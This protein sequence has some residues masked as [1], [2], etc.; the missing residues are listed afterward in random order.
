MKKLFFWI[1][2]FFIFQVK[3]FAQEIS[4]SNKIIEFEK[5]DTFNLQGFTTTNKYIFAVLVNKNDEAAHI[6]VF[7]INTFKEIKSFAE[8]SLGHANDVTYND[9]ENKIYVINNGNKLIHVFDANTLNYLESIK[10]EILLRSLTY[11]KE[12]NLYA[13]RMVTTGY[14]LDSSFNKK[15]IFPF[16]VGLNASTKIGR[17]GWTY[18]NKYIYYTTWSWIRLGGTGSNKIYIYDLDGNKVDELITNNDI[19]EIEDIAFINDKMLLGFNSYDKKIVFYLEDIPKTEKKVSK[20]IDTKNIERRA[21]KKKEN[22]KSKINYILIISLL[23][24]LIF[25]LKLLL[26]KKEKRL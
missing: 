23:F 18:Y 21:T 6:K 5:F 2:I 22:K 20:N 11:M 8:K 26:T 16:I 13:G 15:N 12:Y 10:S 3:I 1:F 19:G 7:D 25:L 24:G 9:K 4:L 14:I 17:Q